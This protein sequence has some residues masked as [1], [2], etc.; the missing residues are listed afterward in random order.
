ML[1][2][3]RD[4]GSLPKLRTG[5]PVEW[6]WKGRRLLLLVTGIGPVNAAQSL[7]RA[8]GATPTVAGVVNAGIAGSFDTARLPLLSVSV[9]TEE[10]WPEFGLRTAEGVDPC[11]LGLPMGG[12]GSGKVWNRLALDPVRNARAMDA[13]LA[14]DWIHAK[15]V[16]VAGVSGSP[17][18]A[19]RLRLSLGSD[20]ENMEGFALAWCCRR[21]DV[22]FLQIRV[23]SNRVGS[24]K[25]EDWDIEAALQRIGSI[26][27]VLTAPPWHG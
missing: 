13:S 26:F 25:N 1:A 14:G 11:G 27:P 16:T 4:C 22:P 19:E 3:L 24:R 20:V 15:S 2:A 7:G 21:E 5:I 12:T 17:D 9:I 10:V 23:V 6:H 18:L 8:L